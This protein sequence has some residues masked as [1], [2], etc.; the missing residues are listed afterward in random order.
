MKSLLIA[1]VLV[2]CTFVVGCNCPGLVDTRAERRNRQELIVNLNTRMMV[3]D[4]DF[5]WLMDRNSYLTYWH[6]RVGP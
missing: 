4:W 2:L 3:D 6:P 1:A 5:F